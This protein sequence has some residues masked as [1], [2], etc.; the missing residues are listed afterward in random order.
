[1]TLRN[2]RD[3]KPFLAP[4]YRPGTNR[5]NRANM[6]LVRALA[7]SAPYTPSRTSGE[8]ALAKKGTKMANETEISPW[9]STA[10]KE[11]CT[12]QGTAMHLT[13][14]GND[15][16]YA[17]K[18]SFRQACDEANIPAAVS[19]LAPFI[20]T[21]CPDLEL[22][23][24]ENM[25]DRA[26]V[27]PRDMLNIPHP[28]ETSVSSRPGAMAPRYFSAFWASFIKPLP[29][30]TRRLLNM[31]PA[32]WFLDVP[33]TQEPGPGQVEIQ[34]EFIIAPDPGVAVS[35]AQMQENITTW[36]SQNQLTPE[37]FINHGKSVDSR[38]TRETASLRQ[39]PSG[40]ER[41]IPR[42][43]F[44]LLPD[45]MKKRFQIPA[46]IVEYLLSLPK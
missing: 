8:I 46:D 45:E 42:R 13:Q 4:G 6:A 44:N 29:E 43:F 34:K 21:F 26:A 15:F 30:N 27:R 24:F 12:S 28:A 7:R 22:L 19:K 40:T 14:L 39:V 11:F 35:N 3:D 37:R 32:V 23:P 38:I 20:Q 33:D 2:C 5:G 25:L 16:R 1:M 17:F 18:K 31:E 10:V 41:E 9:L 36:M